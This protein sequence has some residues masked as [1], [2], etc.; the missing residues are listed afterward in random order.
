MTEGGARLIADARRW[1][2]RL[3]GVAGWSWLLVLGAALLDMDALWR[4]AALAPA[5]LWSWYA[6]AE[7]RRWRRLRRDYGAL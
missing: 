3:L 5:V 4:W 1:F 2:L 6:L 7:W